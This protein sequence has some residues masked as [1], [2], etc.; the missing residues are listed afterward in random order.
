MSEWNNME[1]DGVLIG[2]KIQ[3]EKAEADNDSE[4][5]MDYL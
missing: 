3:P 1:D 4:G 2:N 5:I